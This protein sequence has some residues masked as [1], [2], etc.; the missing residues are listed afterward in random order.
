MAEMTVSESGQLKT[1][2]HRGPQNVFT[3]CVRDP[4]PTNALEVPLHGAG[5]KLALDKN[6]G[7]VCVY[8]QDAKEKRQRGGDSGEKSEEQERNRDERHEWIQ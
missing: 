6:G 8:E 5:T 4:P 3:L 1:G 7:Q 2:V